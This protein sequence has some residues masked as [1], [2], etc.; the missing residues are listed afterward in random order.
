[1]SNVN[2]YTIDGQTKYGL[3]VFNCQRF[4]HDS[5]SKGLELLIVHNLVNGYH[6]EHENSQLKPTA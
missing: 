1:M 3:F 2:T 5:K 4:R 6:V